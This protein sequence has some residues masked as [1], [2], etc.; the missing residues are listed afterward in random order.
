[1]QTKDYE[2]VI[3]SPTA[4]R[5][6]LRKQICGNRIYYLVQTRNLHAEDVIVVATSG[7]KNELIMTYTAQ[8][9]SLKK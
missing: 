7:P 8:F 9:A 3:I 2:W 6:I 1:M 5:C 4:D